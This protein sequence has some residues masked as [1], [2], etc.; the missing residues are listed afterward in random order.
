MKIFTKIEAKY[1][2]LFAVYHFLIEK[3]KTVDESW[4]SSVTNIFM[5]FANY[6]VTDISSDSGDASIFNSIFI[7]LID[8]VVV[9]I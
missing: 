4:W 3:Q 1:T 8:I 6:T 7:I 2:E 9:E 5:N